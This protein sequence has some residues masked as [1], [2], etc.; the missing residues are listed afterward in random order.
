MTELVRRCVSNDEKGQAL[1]VPPF[2]LG[3]K[4]C[5]AVSLAKHSDAKQIS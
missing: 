5:D 1:L 3:S 4:V 2:G